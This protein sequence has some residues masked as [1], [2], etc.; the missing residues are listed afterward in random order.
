QIAKDMVDA[1]L[2]DCKFMG[3]DG[4][5]EAAFIN[6]AGADNVNG[7][8]YVTF[9]GLPP[10]QIEGF[11]KAYMK[12]FKSDKPPEGYAV[13]GYECARV[14]IAA[15]RSAKVK[16]RAAIVEA[17][18][19]LKDFEGA[20]GQWSFDENGDISLDMISGFVVENG[21]FKFVKR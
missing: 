18:L 1:G 8:A 13:Y 21:D 5:Y 20:L 19:N 14:A 12:R 4:C 2:K 15:I 9:G 3:P 6:S 10:Q 17:A 16:D 11:T 7:R